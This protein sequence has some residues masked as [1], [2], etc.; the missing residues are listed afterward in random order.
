MDLKIKGISWVGNIYQKFE[1][2]CHEVDFVSQDKIKYVE[3]QVHTVG[4]SMKK[5]CSNVMQ[6]FLSSSSV[7]SGENKAQALS[8]AKSIDSAME[9]KLTTANEKLCLGMVDKLCA[10]AIL[11][12]DLKSVEVLSSPCISDTT[13]SRRGSINVESS[14]IES[15]AEN[16][17]KSGEASLTTSIHE[18]S[19]E[20]TKEE[21]SMEV[22]SSSNTS[23]IIDMGKSEGSGAFLLN[24]RFNDNVERDY[25][26][27]ERSILPSGYEGKL[28]PTREKSIK[29]EATS[30][31]MPMTSCDCNNDLLPLSESVN[32]DCLTIHESVGVSP[33]SSSCQVSESTE[34][35]DGSNYSITSVD[36]NFSDGTNALLF[37][38]SASKVPNESKEEEMGYSASCSSISMGSCNLLEAD[39]ANSAQE[40]NK[41]GTVPASSCCLLSRESKGFVTDTAASALLFEEVSPEFVTRSSGFSYKQ[42]IKSNE[43][44][45]CTSSH[46]IGLFTSIKR[47]DASAAF[48]GQLEDTTD[49]IGTNCMETI[50]LN[51]EVKLDESCVVVDSCALTLSRRVR[52]PRSYKKIIQDAFASKRRLAKEYEQLAIWYGDI[53]AEFGQQRVQKT[54]SCFPVN[55]SSKND[56]NDSDW[57]LL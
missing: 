40:K 34:K 43:F 53:D 27:S 23:E 41:L 49:V 56:P 30:S 32:D 10:D 28:S 17:C 9:I 52:H 11:N 57:E 4:E 19:S 24:V 47:C 35:M 15:I 7:D 55:S 16:N 18:A 20:S 2:M 21:S 38:E 45:C 22:L 44:G 37:C 31:I 14:V 13:E 42:L 48:A 51:D 54:L 50:E 29:E 6:D 36:N 46:E 33:A 3:N 1:A 5:A 12:P 26:S 8:P 25:N 39:L